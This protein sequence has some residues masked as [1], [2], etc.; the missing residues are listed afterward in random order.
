MTEIQ[1]HTSPTGQPVTAED[2]AKIEALFEGEEPRVVG[3][4]EGHE[5]QPEKLEVYVDGKWIPLK[6]K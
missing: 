5:L 1:K 2:L 4:K 6:K 3:D